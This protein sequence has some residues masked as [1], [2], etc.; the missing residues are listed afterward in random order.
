MPIYE[1]ICSA[2]DTRFEELVRNADQVIACP[3]CQGA[4]LQK[5][6]SVFG[7]TGEAAPKPPAGG[8]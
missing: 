6:F 7:V 5:A 2:C 3:T 4:D 1:Y 8:G